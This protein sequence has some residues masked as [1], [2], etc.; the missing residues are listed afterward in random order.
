MTSDN[1]IDVEYKR[2]PSDNIFDW[3]D[4]IHY[5]MYKPLKWQ[6]PLFETLAHAEEGHLSR[7]MISA[8][9][10]HGKTE[11]LVNTFLSYYLANH[12]NDK[13]IV[14]AYSEA[15][16]TKYGT[17]IRDILKQFR[18][19]TLFKPK[20]KQDFQRKNNFMFD[21]P[22]SGELIATGSHGA[23]MGNPANVIL[24]DDPIKELK[25]AQSPTMQSDL[26]E[27]YYTTIDT[28]LRKRYR[29]YQKALPPLLIVVAQRLDM[30]DLQGIIL[31]E[32]P[33]IDGKEALQKL[34]NGERIPDDVWVEMNFPSLSFGEKEDILNRPVDTPLWSMH[35][36]YNDLQSIRNRLGS[37][38][39]NLVYQGV[40]SEREGTYFKREWFYDENNNLTCLKRLDEVPIHVQS[41]KVRSYDLAAVSKPKNVKNADEVAGALTSNDPQKEELIVYDILNGKFTGSQL[42]NLLKRTIKKDGRSVITNIE[43]EGASQSVLFLEQLQEEMKYYKILSHKPVGSKIYRSLELQALCETGRLKFVTD[44]R[45]IRWII[46]AVEQLISFD[47]SDSTRKRHDDIVD[48]LSASAN[49]WLLENKKPTI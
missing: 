26:R 38:R 22:Y 27:W 45:D 46:K 19:Q 7:L 12:C 21:K 48:S 34:R 31:E 10:Q 8:P 29:K 16:A 17:W 15:R 42:L 44:G 43:Q 33:S 20:L 14:T 32:E 5:G 9:P 24:I 30:F 11:L 37:Y 6:L 3:Y 4:T 47:G 18:E 2:Y 40:P 39:F 13:V 49:Y 28:R 23:I 25:E 36:N 1:L 41:R 35:R